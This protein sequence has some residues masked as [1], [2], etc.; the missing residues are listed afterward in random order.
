M[1]LL[2]LSITL[3]AATKPSE[4]AKRWWHHVQILGADNMEGRDTGSEGYRRAARYVVEQFER[5]GLK[6]A[7]ENGYFQPVPLRA[8][9]VKSDHA[10]IALI[11]DGRSTALRLNYDVGVAPRAGLPPVIEGPLF[12]VGYGH[13]DIPDLKGKVAV[14]LNALPVGISNEDRNKATADRTRLLAQ[15]GAVAIVALDNPRAIEPPRWPIPYAVAMSLEGVERNPAGGSALNIRLNS[16]FADPILQGTGHSFTELLDLMSAGKAPPQFAIP[17]SLR[18]QVQVD[19][20]KLTSD[21][22]IGMLPGSELP[23]EYV[24]VSAHLDAYGFGE[25]INGDKLYNGAFDDAACVA[26][27]LELAADLHRSGKKLRRSLAFAVFTGEEKGLLGSSYFTSH[28]T[29]AKDRVVADINL[30]YIRPMFPLKILTALG[31]GESTLGESAKKV[32]ESLG[33]RIQTDSEPERGLFRRSDQYNFIRAGIPGIAFIFGYENGSSEEKIY[34]DW[35][36]NRYHRPADDIKQPVDMA[37]AEKFQQFFSKLAETVAD[38]PERPRWY[39]SSA[40]GK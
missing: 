12:F 11:R 35:Y 37:A 18:A 32:G 2:A 34:R 16:A 7:G 20:E 5:S 22:L 29:V 30:D 38:A 1:L 33:I 36:A 8:L 28:L 15:S 21:N 26:N 27:L 14:Y 23:E 40:Y 13:K 25:P 3:I 31:M 4:A 10:A 9:R 17:E 19:E 39:P 24:V 6:P